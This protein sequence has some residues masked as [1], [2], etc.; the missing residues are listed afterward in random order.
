[1][2]SDVGCVRCGFSEGTGSF[3]VSKVEYVR[4]RLQ[5]AQEVFWFLRFDVLDV[6]FQITIKIPGSPRLDVLYVGFQRA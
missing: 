4:C 3:L 1:M 2:F 6:G 5:R